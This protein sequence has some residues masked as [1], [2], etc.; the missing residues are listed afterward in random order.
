L[1]TCTRD[2]TAHALWD[3]FSF[4]IS[5]TSK[6]ALDFFEF[7]RTFYLINFFCTLMGHYHHHSEGHRTISHHLDRKEIVN[8]DK[9]K[10][11]WATGMVTAGGARQRTNGFQ[12]GFSYFGT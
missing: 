5:E 10:D 12:M 4:V 2:T 1:F 7:G 6:Q 3:I 9:E 11:Q 8:L